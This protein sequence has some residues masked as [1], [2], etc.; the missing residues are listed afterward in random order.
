[1]NK[2]IEEQLKTD[3]R[4]GNFLPEN[5]I[6]KEPDPRLKKWAEE[7]EESRAQVEELEQKLILFRNNLNL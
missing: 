4:A 7:A 2:E 6:S 5:Y 3:Y 1:M